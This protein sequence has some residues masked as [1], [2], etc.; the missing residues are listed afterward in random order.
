M[1]YSEFVKVYEALAGTTKRLEKI[2]ILSGLLKKL[3]GHEDWVYLLR[4]RVFPDYDESEFGISTQLVI[5]AIAKTAGVSEKEINSKF[6][7]VGDLG[8][9]AEDIVGKK[10]QSTLFSKNLSV[11]LVYSNLRRLS[12][13]EGKG[14]VEKKMG[15]ISELLGHS[16]GVESKY[17]V[18]TLLNDL[19]VGVADATLRDGIGRAFFWRR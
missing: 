6:R 7:K 1:Q 16:S 15:L 19:R 3:E 11:D 5:K 12:E 14:S 2:D 8:D 17:I 13:I 9:I 18:R 4:G 10:K